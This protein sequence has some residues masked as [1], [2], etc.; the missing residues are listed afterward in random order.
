MKNCILFC[1]LCF[2]PNL[3]AQLSFPKGTTLNLETTSSTL[4][5]ETGIYFHTGQYTVADYTWTR[6]FTDSLD[7]RWDFQACMNGD[8][9]IG[10]PNNGNFISDFGLNDTTGFI[11]FHVYTFDS[12]GRSILK[13]YV[14]NNQ[15]ANDQALL[16]FNISYLNTTGIF[17]TTKPSSTIHVYPNPSTDVLTINHTELLAGEIR[18]YNMLNELVF[19]QSLSKAGEENIDTR[20]F[21]NGIYLLVSGTQHSLFVVKHN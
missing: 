16:T 2:G 6:A 13:Y 20:S 12:T 19:A 10:L 7:L 21:Q 5:N 17:E 9:K 15:D 4:Y 11:K 3:F 18:I 14:R 1:L 8:C